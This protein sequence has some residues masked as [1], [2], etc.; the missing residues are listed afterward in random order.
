M[1]AMQIHSLDI[2]LPLFETIQNLIYDLRSECL[3]IL[4]TT[5]TREILANL[6]FEEQDWIVDRDIDGDST[7]LITKLVIR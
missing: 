4:L 3:K 5:P 2:P 1:C 7:C 6:G